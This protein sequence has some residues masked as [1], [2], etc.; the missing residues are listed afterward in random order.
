MA[1]SSPG[2]CEALVQ[3]TA[4][5]TGKEREAA[6]LV[7][8]WVQEGV[9]YQATWY[10]NLSSKKKLDVKGGNRLVH[11]NGVCYVVTL[12]KVQAKTIS[13]VMRTVTF[14]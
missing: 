13:K 8:P 12:L 4:P 7:Y 1:D 10:K 2:M 14:S 5:H 9:C 11:V 6:F 3:C